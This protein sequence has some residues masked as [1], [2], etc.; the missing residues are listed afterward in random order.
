MH[1]ELVGAG[2]DHFVQ[3][4]GFG[5]GYGFGVEST[6]MFAQ[7][8]ER[9]LPVTPTSPFPWH[10]AA[11]PTDVN[12]G[13]YNQPDNHVVAGDVISIIN[14]INA[15]ESGPIPDDAFFGFPFGF[16]DTTR[17]NNVA[18]DDVL[19]IINAINAGL[20]GERESVASGTNDAVFSTNDPQLAAATHDYWID[21]IALV[22]FDTAQQNTP[23]KN[24]RR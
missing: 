3:A 13:P 16:L 17:D 23:R 22:A 19:R 6:G 14:Y 2:Q 11:R 8:E 15:N 18:A 21:L 9:T 10:N 4:S 12:G 1:L 20:G 24:L 5:P 7:G